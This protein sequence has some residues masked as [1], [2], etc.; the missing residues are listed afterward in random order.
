VKTARKARPSRE[1]RYLATVLY[2]REHPE[3]AVKDVGGR[4][5][6]PKPHFDVAWHLSSCRML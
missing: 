5:G 6:H 2:Y 3:E 4:K 1:E